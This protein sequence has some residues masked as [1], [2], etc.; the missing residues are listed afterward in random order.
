VTR[1]AAQGGRLDTTLAA[2]LAV[3]WVGFLLL[4]WYDLRD[5]F[6]AFTWLV[7]GWPTA[8]A[9]A[10]ALMQG[11]LHGKIWLLPLGLFLVPPLLALAR[12]PAD[13][14]RA[15]LLLV[16]GGGGLAWLVLQGLAI[17]IGGFEWGWLERL[18]GPLGD[19]QLGMGVGAVLTATA[20]LFI[21]THGLAAKGAVKGDVFVAGAIGLV[22]ALVTTFIF[23]PVS[24]IL[25][26]AVQDSR[27]DFAPAL[28]VARF[29]DSRIWSLDCLLGGTRCG[30]AWNTLLLGVLTALSTTSLGLAFALVV[31]RTDFRFKRMLRVLTV[32]PI[33]TPPFVVG[34]AI[35][36]LFGRAGVVTQFLAGSFGLEAS[37]WIY[38]LPG[39][40]LAQTLAFTP[41]AFLVLIGVV[42]G[43][44]PA[45]EEAA[46]TLRA[47]AWRTFTTVSFPLMR[48]GFANA[49]LLSFIESLADFGNPLILG[50]RYD[51]LA[52]EI[53]FAIVGAQHD[54]GRAAVLAIVLLTFTL[55]AFWAQNRWL[56]KKAYT[57]VT[58]KGDSGI[59]VALPRRLKGVAFSVALPWAAFTA[60]VYLMIM[61]GGFVE[62]WGRDHS[63]T[64]RHY[65]TAF[66]ITTGQ[67]G[68][69]WSGAAWNSLFTTV[70]IALIAAIPT[71]LIGL[72]TA[73]LLARQ[74]FRG[75]AAFEFGSMLSFAIPGTVI[76]VAYII[77]FNVPPIEITGTGIILI[78]AFVFR[79][80]PVGVRAGIATLAQLDKSLDEAS[81]TLGA[82]TFTTV[83]RIV[84]PL[85]RPA[86]VAALVY[87]FVTAMTAVSA[88]VFLVSARY[89]MAT[90]YILGRV[91][92]GDYGLAIAYCS[93]LIL[94]MLASILLFQVVVG[95]RRLGRRG[96][97]AGGVPVMAGG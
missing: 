35:I 30:T 75:K 90:T 80:M 88:V 48:P 26:G 23:F 10:P 54:P 91:E 25:Q 89:D 78:I 11:L 92:A 18:L 41:I 24:S 13:P 94:I 65:E 29:T 19:R 50:G 16:G 77:A 62:I 76:G 73:Y 86:M 93:V 44:S 59:P 57:T 68:L 53:Y 67:F 46:Q 70:Q 43:V 17:G 36:L 71:A 52:T 64:L 33:I 40:W 39:V 96:E 79:N 21:L 55:G 81:L 61:F 31:T 58:G 51:V 6:F 87:S 66:R 8:A 32:L 15:T 14:A 37:R 2:W 45:M 60:I 84:F 9:V 4:P 47:D 42:E 85:M 3:G 22:V 95:R 34:L 20:F 97:A 49:F 28:F 38:G 7:R 83:R 72:L 63:L 12:D 27:G 5:G 74:Q 1:A 82:N 69:V 56:G